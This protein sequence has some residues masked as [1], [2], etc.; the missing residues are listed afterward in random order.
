MVVYEASVK[1]YCSRDN[2]NQ[3]NPKEG[4]GESSIG[5]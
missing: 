2:V 4:R 3:M 5:T 1:A